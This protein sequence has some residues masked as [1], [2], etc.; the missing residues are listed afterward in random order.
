MLKVSLATAVVNVLQIKDM[1]IKPIVH[2]R[3]RRSILLLVAEAFSNVKVKSYLH[4]IAE[5]D[6]QKC[7]KSMIMPDILLSYLIK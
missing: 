6:F 4:N 1:K 3:I 7:H 5:D 2:Y